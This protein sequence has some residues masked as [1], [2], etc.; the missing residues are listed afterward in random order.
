VI[1]VLN[2]QMI[3]FA[4]LMLVGLYCLGKINH[5]IA[6]IKPDSMLYHYV[7]P[8]LSGLVYAGVTWLLFRSLFL[9]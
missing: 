6:D 1:E 2:I 5:Y 8:V 3:G 4:L 9:E 7:I